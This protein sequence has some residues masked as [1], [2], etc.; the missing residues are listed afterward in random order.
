MRMGSLCSAPPLMLSPRP[1]IFCLV[2]CTIRSLVSG[3][4]PLPLLLFRL[5]EVD[6]NEF[7]RLPVVTEDVRLLFVGDTAE[8]SSF[9]RVSSSID[10]CRRTSSGR[11]LPSLTLWQEGITE[12]VKDTWW[13][14]WYSLDHPRANLEVLVDFLLD[15]IHFK[16]V[17]QASGRVLGGGY[18]ENLLHQRVTSVISFTVHILLELYMIYFRSYKDFNGAPFRCTG[19]NTNTCIPCVNIFT[20]TISIKQLFHIHICAVKRAGKFCS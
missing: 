11:V 8:S 14:L 2:T 10:S 7:R 15:G 4:P 17:L 13:N 16:D 18:Q 12:L 1:P 20:N 6:D 5:F 9:W 3:A 19:S